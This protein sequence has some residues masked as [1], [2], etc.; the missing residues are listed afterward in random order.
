V[1]PEEVLQ[2]I[3]IMRYLS[4]PHLVKLCEI[5]DD[6]A[7]KYLYLVMEYIEVCLLLPLLLSVSLS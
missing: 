5:V 4:H 1:L 2:E 6:K 7:S 3:H